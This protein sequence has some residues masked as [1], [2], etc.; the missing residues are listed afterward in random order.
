MI[1]IALDCDETLNVSNGP[2]SISRLGE[3]NIPPYIQVVIVSESTLCS[4]LPFPRF[5]N[6]NRL[7]PRSVTRLENLLSAALRYPSLLNIYVSDNAGDDEIAKNAGF[8]Y[9]HPKYF[10][11]PLK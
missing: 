4:Q 5:V 10:H 7:R 8:V 1:L 9:I 6:G 2:I 11:F 3:I